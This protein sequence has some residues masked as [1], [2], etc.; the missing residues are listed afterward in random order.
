MSE[1][2]ELKDEERLRLHLLG[3]VIE[4][5]PQRKASDIVSDANQLEIFVLASG[6]SQPCSTSDKE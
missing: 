5:N 2:P 3:L 4:N 1:I 6:R